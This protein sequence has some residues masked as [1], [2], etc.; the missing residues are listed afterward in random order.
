MLEDLFYGNLCPCDMDQRRDPRIQPLM[1]KVAETEDT[2][3]DGLPDDAREKLDDFANAN[4]ALNL[5][6]MNLA[7]HDGFNIAAGI[8]LDL[9]TAQQRQKS[10]GDKKGSH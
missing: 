9:Y 2:L 1:Q 7:F 4:I 3:R 5:L 6:M 8:S 10:Q